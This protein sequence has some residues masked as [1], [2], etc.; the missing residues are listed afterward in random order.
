MD[1]HLPT[2]PPWL[3]HEPEAAHDPP[4]WS[5]PLD[6]LRLLF[7]T[8]WRL[9]RLWR[10]TARV[11]NLGHPYRWSARFIAASI[12][13]LAVA[14][15]ALVG[16]LRLCAV[17]ASRMGVITDRLGIYGLLALAIMP[18]MAL[19]PLIRWPVGVVA[20]LAPIVLV[21]APLGALVPPAFVHGTQAVLPVMMTATWGIRLG[22]V[23]AL[24]V[25]A[26]MATAGGVLLGLGDGVAFGLAVAAIVVVVALR[27]PQ[28]LLELALGGWLPQFFDANGVL[29]M[30]RASRR[31]EAE[32]HSGAPGP[33]A[34]A[35][36][37][38]PLRRW[39]L[40]RALAAHLAHH[41]SPGA[42]RARWEH[43]PALGVPE[44][45]RPGK[46]RDWRPHLREVWLSCL[47]PAGSADADAL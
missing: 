44:H 22:P 16:V 38:N 29:P 45:L 23:G 32:L 28:W 18:A 10:V 34:V 3:C 8:F 25:G 21:I 14:W 35:L 20:A 47:P 24:V 40:R 33:V 12:P 17:D 42:L 1:A 27:L 9:D 15:L 13:T 11:E 41:P 2:D 43:E 6:G 37:R 7:W 4:R 19:A 31:V 36:A 46:G 5:R 26:V 30:P 39:Q